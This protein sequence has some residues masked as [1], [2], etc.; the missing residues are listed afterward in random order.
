MPPRI[1]LSGERLD[2][3][4]AYLLENGE[5]MMLWLGRGVL[6]EFLEKVF[7][8]TDLNAVDINMVRYFLVL[9]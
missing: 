9:R 1:R 6:P 8:V 4:G 2:P 3:Q 5:Q 7:G